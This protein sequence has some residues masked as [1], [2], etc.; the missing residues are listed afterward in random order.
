VPGKTQSKSSRIEHRGWYLWGVTIALVMALAATVVLFYIPLLD[1]MGSTD[2]TL[3][4]GTES[5]NT[6]LVV[7]G[8]VLLFSLYSAYKHVELERTRKALARES[9]DAENV[10]ARLSEISSLFQLSTTLNLQLRLDVM[11]EIIARRI[12][13]AVRAQQASIMLYNPELGILET[14]ASYGLEAEFARNARKRLGE[15]IAGW[16]AKQQQAVIL[17]HDAPSTALREHFKT[18]RNITSALSLPL[19]VGDRCVGVLNV[20]RINHPEPFSEDHRQ[21]LE[22]FAEHVGAVIDRAETMDRLGSR[23]RELEA[24]NQRLT[25]TNQ[26]KD[27]F[28]STASHELKTPLTSVIA[29]AELLDENEG[30]LSTPQRAEFLRRLRGEAERLLSLIDDILDLTRLESGKMVLKPVPLS[31][32]EVIHAAV[33]TSRNMA[34][35]KGVELIEEPGDRIP[36]IPIDEVKLRQVIVNLIVNAIKFSPRGSRV[37]ARSDREPNYVRVD[38]RDEGPGIEPDETATIFELF[39]QGVPKDEKGMGVGIGLHLVKRITELHGGHVGVNSVPGEGSTF[40]VRLPVALAAAD[41][42][43]AEVATEA[44]TAAA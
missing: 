16:V 20:N 44:A 1:Q 25:E 4:L 34:L 10:Q 30:Q 40:W 36:L 11:L 6:I 33:E 24:T 2:E 32:N 5:Y 39:G 17:T 18:D 29:Y 3:T 38:V 8:L 21:V 37:R 28:L 9:R 13:S 43:T 23:S 35:K 26:M 27:L 14:R 19:R 31:V 15:G 22:M 41:E 12:V 42:P 7:V